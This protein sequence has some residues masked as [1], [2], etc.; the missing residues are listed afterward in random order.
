MNVGFGNA[1]ITPELPA[2]LA[3]FGARKGL[4]TGVH[5]D[6][7][8]QAVVVRSED[9][10]VCLLVLDLLLLGADFADP[11]RRAVGSALGIEP[12]RVMTSCTHT[13]AGPAATSAVR[14]IGWPVPAG[15]LERLVDGCVSAATAALA[16]C[17]PATLSYARTALPAGLSMNRRGLPYDPSYAVLD[18]RRP[19]GT[20]I[21]SIANV[22]IHPVALG[23]TCTQVSGDWVAAFRDAANA[24]TG[25]PAVLLPG[26]LGDVNPTRDPHTDPDAGGNWETARILGSEIADCVGRLLDD[27][28]ILPA[29]LE[30][31]PRRPLR[32]RAGAT[33][34]ALLNGALLRAVDVELQEWSLGGVRLVSV[35]GEA[36]HALGR[37]VERA[38]GD[39]ALLAGLASAYQ[40]YLPA[41]FGRG[42]EEKMSYGRGFVRGLTEALLDTSVAGS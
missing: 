17:E 39:K 9:A 37:A 28:A 12:A 8:A 1:V 13:H 16:A 33:V 27:C 4:A 21:G 20:R 22:G 14:R 38:R 40:G 32:L 23:V 35:P 11:V 42:Y 10:A 6:L 5:D 24:A 7:T 3:G 25:A 19:D 31:L 41:P 15:Y 34:P 18:V 2:V 36:F 29:T 26:A 30:V